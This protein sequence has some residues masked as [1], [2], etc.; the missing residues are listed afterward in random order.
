MMEEK[1]MKSQKVLWTNIVFFVALFFLAGCGALFVSKPPSTVYELD[2]KVTQPEEISDLGLTGLRLGTT[3]AEIQQIFTQ[4]GL[5]SKKDNSE[6]QLAYERPPKN[7]LLLRC[8]EVNLTFVADTLNVITLQ[9]Y[10]DLDEFSLYT[11]PA[12]FKYYL[13]DTYVRLNW[14]LGEPARKYHTQE[15]RVSTT[16]DITNIYWHLGKNIIQLRTNTSIL[17]NFIAVDLLRKK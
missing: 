16:V 9:I 5:E 8:K 3:K 12:K 11:R 14:L 15:N 7:P 4:L 13:Q 6:D 2:P 10:S 17:A 1:T